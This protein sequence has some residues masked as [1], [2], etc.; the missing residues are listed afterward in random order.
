ML[1]RKL[2]RYDVAVETGER[3]SRVRQLVEDRTLSPFHGKTMK[4]VFM[5]AM[6]VGFKNGKRVPLKKR[7]AAIP[8]ATFSEEDEALIEAVAIKTKST[9]DVLFEDSAKQV[10]QIAEEYANGGIDALYYEVFGE[11]AGDPDRKME[12]SVRDWLAKKK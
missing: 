6:A 5:Y 1:K 9:I 10:I 11:E 3:H 2:P 4:E 8:I 7:T 12:Q